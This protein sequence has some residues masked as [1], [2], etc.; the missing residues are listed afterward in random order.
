VEKAGESEPMPTKSLPIKSTRGI[1]LASL[2]A[3]A[4][5]EQLKGKLGKA[6]RR[7][8]G[9]IRHNSEKEDSEE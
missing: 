5:I 3:A 1:G 8:K 2:A 4:G 7:C 6:L 9:L